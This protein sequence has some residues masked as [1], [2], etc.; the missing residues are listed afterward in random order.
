[1]N[2]MTT[3][4]AATMTATEA[5]HNALNE[6]RY[7]GGKDYNLTRRL[8]ED[9]HWV[10]SL[11]QRLPDFSKSDI[12]SVLDSSGFETWMND[13]YTYASA[14]RLIREKLAPI[15]NGEAA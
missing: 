6:Y 3:P 5:F 7:T 10:R 15:V 12:E 8:F 14:A 11:N 4:D 1:M 9:A 13:G 2:T